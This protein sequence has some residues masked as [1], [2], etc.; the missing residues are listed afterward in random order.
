M[1]FNSTPIATSGTVTTGT[2]TLDDKLKATGY[3]T[4]DDA[5]ID[6]YLDE[7]QYAES[8]IIVDRSDQSA[9]FQ[10]SGVAMWDEAAARLG[11]FR[12]FNQKGTEQYDL[13]TG[14]TS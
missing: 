13:N 1:N 11:I 9:T 12:V 4:A 8:P 3:N 10:F 7:V 14:I 5:V 6:I 2:S